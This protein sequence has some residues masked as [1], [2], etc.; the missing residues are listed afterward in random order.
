MPLNTINV[1]DIKTKVQFI[2]E[3]VCITLSGGANYSM[4]EPC[5]EHLI[6]LHLNELKVC[7]DFYY[8]IQHLLEVDDYYSV[9]YFVI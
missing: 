2:A 7:W 4:C 5:D 6:E 9:D 3:F 8:G 1:T